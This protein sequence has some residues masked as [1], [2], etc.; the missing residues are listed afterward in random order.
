M[1]FLFLRPEDEGKDIKYLTLPPLGLLYLG[2]VLEQDGHNVEILDYCVEN[3]SREKLGNALMS[4]DAVGMTVY[5][6]N[7]RPHI[8]ISRRIKDLDPDIPLIIGGPHCSFV[9][10]R[11]IRD[12]PHADISVI[13]EGEHVILDLARFLQGTKNLADIQGIYYRDNG[14]IISGK[15][16]KVID[17]LDVLPFPARHLV[18][19]Y[20]YG[21]SPFGFQLKKK[22][23]S[24][25]TS[26]G[27]PFHCR[28]CTRYAN[29]IDGWGFRQRSAENILQEFAEIDEKY[30]SLN[31]VD[32]SF[33]ADKKRAHKI[34]DGLIEIG[35]E[36]ELVIHGARVDSA[37][38]EL[39]QK[40]KK[41]GVKYIYFG[42]ES[43][44]QDVLDFYNK[45][46]TLSQIKQAVHLSR[47]MNFVTIGNFIFGAPIETEEHIEKT[48]KFACS[49]PLDIAGF[50]PLIYIRGS[51]LWN[52]A[53]ES[54]KISKE[55]DVVFADSR[56]GLGNF[57]KKELMEYTIKAFQRFYF[58]PSYLL[59]QIYRSMLRNDYSLLLDGLR[60]LFFAKKELDIF[61]NL[62]FPGKNN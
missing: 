22:V 33:L 39:Y 37:D 28:F 53:V 15:P 44:N 19:K 20:D 56:E 41:A 46:T 4:S 62:N 60:L 1:K 9:Q 55:K 8:N 25:I 51:Q 21:D 13:G 7:I 49:L 59:S 27:C 10:E 40:M 48:I 29:V 2:A 45:K 58:R 26:R 12:I 61:Q 31:I 23:T 11:S 43:G 5:T 18:E 6:D 42:L 38:K 47:K 36:T 30:N 3:V 32:D 16:L 14:S 17:N 24:S 54:K 35:R 50:G 34:F 52:E 57:T